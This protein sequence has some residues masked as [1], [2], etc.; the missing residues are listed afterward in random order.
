[1]FGPGQDRFLRA[2]FA[3]VGDDV[4]PVVAARL[5]DALSSRDAA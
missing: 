4:A 2:A 5:T 3:N 1:M